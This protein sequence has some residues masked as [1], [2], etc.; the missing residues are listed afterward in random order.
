MYACPKKSTRHRNC[1][2]FVANSPRH[3][4]SFLLFLGFSC[5]TNGFLSIAGLCLKAPRKRSP[6]DWQ[7][8]RDYCEVR[9]VIESVFFLYIFCLIF[10]SIFAETSVWW[11]VVRASGLLVFPSGEEEAQGTLEIEGN[12]TILDRRKIENRRNVRI[13]CL[14]TG[15]GT[16][17]CWITQ[18]FTPFRTAHYPSNRLTFGFEICGPDGNP[19]ECG[20]SKNKEQCASLDFLPN[21]G[22]EIKFYPCQRKFHF[23]CEI[24][25]GF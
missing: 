12:R 6:L 3:R 5:P 25:E 8:A 23:I 17:I 16:L 19:G 10:L 21:G 9:H 18:P 20:L 22:Q 13:F 2:H 14:A 15:I 11:E 1:N 7:G 4:F 24:N